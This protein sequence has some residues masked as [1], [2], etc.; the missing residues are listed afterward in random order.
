METTLFDKEIGLIINEINTIKT[1][2]I[3][4]LTLDVFNSSPINS[5]KMNSSRD[6]H[7]VDER[8][9]WGNLIHTLRVVKICDTL[10]D[11]LNLPQES[12]DI[13]KSA[14]ILHDSCKHGLNAEYQFITYD[15]P[16]LVKQLIEKSKVECPFKYQIIDI[17]SRHMG[18]W[19]KRNTPTKTVCDWIDGNHI[20]LA[21]LLHSADCIE[22]RLPSVIE[23]KK[24]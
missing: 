23:V 3:K 14:A 2:S 7:M 1:Q 9:E 15:H 19:D 8:G 24:E 16:Y 18:R 10:A 11:V 20:T 13:L 6:H 17:I 5:W 21:F 22:A 12:K 4:D